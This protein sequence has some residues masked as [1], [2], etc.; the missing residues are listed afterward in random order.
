MG[1]ENMNSGALIN[2]LGWTPLAHAAL[3]NGTMPLILLV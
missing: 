2:W 3:V 1:Q